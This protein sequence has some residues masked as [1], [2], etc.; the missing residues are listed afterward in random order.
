M[1]A[2]HELDALLG[3]VIHYRFERTA[4]DALSS[5]VDGQVAPHS[6]KAQVPLE[7]LA[8]CAGA[9]G[10]RPWETRA[11]PGWLPPPAPN[12]SRVSAPPRKL[13]LSRLRSGTQPTRHWTLI[14]LS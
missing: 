10:A 1:Y 9:C 7:R 5:D 3:S 14:Q 12:S 11:P 2:C 13:N 4:D 6:G 8:V